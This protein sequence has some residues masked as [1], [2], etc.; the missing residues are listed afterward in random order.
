MAEKKKI[1]IFQLIKYHFSSLLL[2]FGVYF[3]THLPALT[4]LPVFADEAIYIRWTQLMMDDWQTYAFFPLN[5]G[6]T[7]LL[8]WLM[9]PF[10][11]LFQDQL[12]AARMLS[13][14]VG[15]IQV[16]VMG[17]IVRAIGG[18]KR[19]SLLVMLATII[20]PF[21][22]FHH[23]MALIESLLNLTLSFALLG[24]I[25]IVKLPLIQLKSNLAN[26]DRSLVLRVIG[27]VFFTG[28]M[29]GLAMLTKIPALLW[30]PAA[31]LFVL[32][33]KQ[34]SKQHFFQSLFLISTAFSL[35]GLI[36]LSLKLHPAFPQLF[37]RGSD[38]LYPWREVILEG[39][40]QETILNFPS[41]L[42]YF[43]VYL[44]PALLLM[45][46]A[47]LFNNKHQRLVHLFFWSAVLFILP[48]AILGKVVYPRYFFPAAIFLTIGGVMGLEAFLSQLL[49][50]G[51]AGRKHF[52]TS[53]LVAV[54]GVNIFSHSGQFI[55]A[56]LFET[57]ATP[58]VSADRGQYLEEWS[59]GH[60]IKEVADK[61]QLEAKDQTIA[62]ATEG[63]FGTLPDGLL[64][65]LHREDVNNIY[66]E[67]IGQP[68][69]DFPESFVERAS[70]FNQI[71]LLVNSHRL[72]I[73]LA[74]DQ[75]IE[76]YCRPGKSPCLQLWNVTSIIRDLN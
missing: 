10:Q 49:E 53:V 64:L 17:L 8:M 26:I 47:G 4:T 76:E 66:V 67:G 39:R 69:H 42:N 55:W 75:L 14:L 21:W 32:L 54:I 22:Y 5:D 58:F 59:S 46:L 52:V 40:W 15:A 3:L 74:D 33:P 6:K 18:S 43:L 20:L 31:F 71:W 41:Y 16:G 7:P 68:V 30:M 2:I 61:L 38:F 37:A 27:L 62:V 36:F 29:F 57:D 11:Y 12:F 63:Y 24:V 45:L 35:G 9:V 48:I 23:R 56:A 70:D 73:E 44:S 50:T 51:R 1:M 28:G 60:G 19:A 72:E 34:F 25:G 65:Y 13:V